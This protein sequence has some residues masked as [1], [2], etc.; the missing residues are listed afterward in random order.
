MVN[1]IPKEDKRQIAIRNLGKFIG[2]RGKDHP[3]W[4]GGIYYNDQGYR[5]IWSPDHPKKDKRGYVREHRLVME[6]ILGRFLRHDELIHHINGNKTD[7]RERNLCIVTRA[8]HASMH[9]KKGPEI[10]EAVL[11]LRS[12]GM[13]I[14]RISTLVAIDRDTVSKILK[15]HNIST[16]RITLS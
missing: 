4:K 3:R 2:I 10:I 1:T 14:R 8:E 9:H 12:R 11:N 16:N 7:N 6:K 13:S 15:E 5:L